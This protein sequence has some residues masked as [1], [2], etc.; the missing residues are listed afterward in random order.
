MREEGFIDNRV[1]EV[2]FAG[3]LTEL[4]TTNLAQ[5]P[6]KQAV[7]RRM[8]GVVTIDLEDIE[9]AV[10]LVFEKGKLR[11]QSEV[12]ACPDLR[13]RTASDRV[14]DLNA[15]RII[16]GLP[17]YFDEAGRKVA[18]HLLSG[19]LKIEGMFGHPFLLTRLTKIMSVM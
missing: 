14:T 5:H 2:P 8:R 9:T 7:F 4:L 13:I 1:E 10:T 3:I 18:A 15:L 12:A 17:W 16:G 11:I 6:E 19:R